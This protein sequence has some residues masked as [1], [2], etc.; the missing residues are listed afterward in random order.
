MK[1]DRT[2]NTSKKHTLDS[3][4][5]L[6]KT[7]KGEIEKG[8]ITLKSGN[9]MYIEDVDGNK[10]LDME[11]GITRPVCL[12]YANEYV[13][14]AVYNQIMELSYATPCGR[15][16][17]PA[18]ELSERLSKVAPKNINHFT[19][20]SSGS[21][22][23]ESAMKLARLYHSAQGN[24]H[25]YKV[26]S[27]MGA[28]HGVGGMGLRALG[29]MTPMRHSFEP[30]TPGAI[31]V[32]S[33]YCYRC[34]FGRRYPDCNLEC[35]KEVETR[36]LFEDPDLFS[37]F[38]GEAIQQGF[39]SYAPPREYWDEVRAIC[40]KYE[41][42]HIDDEVICGIGR[43]GKMFAAEHYD[44]EP[45]LMTMAKCISSG[46]VPLAAV[47][48]SDKVYDVVDNFMHLHTYGNHP[49]A[50]AAGIATLDVLEKEN[51]I[52]KSNAMGKYLK[53]TLADALDKRP[54]VGEI[55]GT[56]LWVSIDFTT[57]QETRAEFP[58]SNLNSI[59]TQALKLGY[60]I[61]AMPNVIELAPAYII[62]KENIDDFVKAFTQCIIDEEKRMGLAK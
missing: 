48:I 36:L 27:R 32:N 23:V 34:P 8:I 46:Y 51:L 49:V 33:P 6:H 12:G 47:G 5:V 59:I 39:G 41:I 60:M 55:R 28:Y 38:I 26:I 29:L 54:S 19:Y 2:K 53:E 13:A 52:E 16:N 20:E 14:K 57:N 22:A 45:D 62:S 4:L 35:A 18:M 61:K 50:C 44:M 9:G 40:K 56:G 25:R 15:S 37:A 30:L 10:Y 31:F 3:K 43:T 1:T 58:M 17:L 11:S 24:K 42:L 21:E 7:S